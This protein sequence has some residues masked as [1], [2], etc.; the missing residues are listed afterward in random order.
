MNCSI[1]AARGPW[2]QFSAQ[3]C[4]FTGKLVSGPTKG[5]KD[6]TG[7]QEIPSMGS[8]RPPVHPCPLSHCG[9]LEGTS[10][11][12]PCRLGIWRSPRPQSQGFSEEQ[13][14]AQEAGIVNKCW[15]I[16]MVTGDRH[17]W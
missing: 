13:A 10:E 14:A 4:C 2:S 15:P 3:M 8:T 17:P 12:S 5:K 7:P 1:P 6:H 11:G 9:H 16:P